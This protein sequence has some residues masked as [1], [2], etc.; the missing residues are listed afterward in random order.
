MKHACNIH[1]Q[2]HTRDAQWP[3]P[4]FLPLLHTTITRIS[5]QASRGLKIN[6]PFL[7]LWDQS[8]GARVRER[9]QCGE[10]LT[11]VSL[12][13]IDTTHHAANNITFSCRKASTPQLYLQGTLRAELWS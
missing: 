6:G 4:G 8:K 3:D 5:A 2:P 9:D 7:V 11:R 10:I 1:S 12:R 13:S